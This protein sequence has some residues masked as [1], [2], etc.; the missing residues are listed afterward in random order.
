MNNVK[1]ANMGL[2]F[3]VEV[4]MWSAFTYWGFHHSSTAAKWLL[5]IGTPALTIVVWAIWAAPKAEKRL[6]QPGLILL[7]L[8]LFILAGLALISAGKSGWALIFLAFAAANQA[9]EYYFDTHP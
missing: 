9:L 1:I 8:T 5:G 4:A 3:F 7:K 6:K 2:S